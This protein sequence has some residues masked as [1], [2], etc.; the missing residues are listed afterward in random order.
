MGQMRP[1]DNGP[2]KI[3][4]YKPS[5]FG[6]HYLTIPP[7][8]SDIFDFLRF[9]YKAQIYCFVENLTL[10]KNYLHLKDFNE[11]FLL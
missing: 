2:I 1:Y 3:T 5:F 8:T 10:N 9:F 7:N 6:F 11:T 4:E